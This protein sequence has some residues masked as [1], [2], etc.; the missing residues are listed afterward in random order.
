M[1][2]QLRFARRQ[3]YPDVLVDRRDVELQLTGTF[4]LIWNAMFFISYT[5]FRILT[6]PLALWL[7]FQIEWGAYVASTSS[8]NL[9]FTLF[10][11]IPFAL[12]IFWY[13]LI[14][15]AAGKMLKPPSKKEA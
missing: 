4:V 13:S 1:D 8:I 11:I 6:I 9:F 14:V 15:K 7:M 5:V 3:P 2:D 12:N 10:C